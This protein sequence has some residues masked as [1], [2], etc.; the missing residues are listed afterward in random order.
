MLKRKKLPNR[1]VERTC[2]WIFEAILLLLDEKPYNKITVSDITAK[3]GIARQTFY[4]NF[5]DKDEVIIQYFANIFISEFMTVENIEN[6]NKHENIL[7]TFNINYMVNH[8]ANL[9]KIMSAIGIENLLLERFNEWQ[10]MLINQGNK[11]L[12]NEM[13]LTYRYKL[14][15]QIT[16]ILRII[17]DW[18]KND[19]PKP[20]N[21]LVKLINYLTVDTK[22]NY[23]DVPNIKI[24]IITH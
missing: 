1:Q 24:K 5:R 16:G 4:R 2:S 3:A 12:N 23:V 13:R 14:I 11:K 20:V 10:E 8:H 15:Y 7:L 9:K 21:D 17:L 6:K 22:T 19:M 18:F